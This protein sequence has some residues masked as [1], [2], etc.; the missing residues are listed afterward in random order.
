[1]R[2][3]NTKVDQL[4]GGCLGRLSFFAVATT[5]TV[6]VMIPTATD[7]P[8]VSTSASFEN[9][10]SPTD[11]QDC[12]RVTWRQRGIDPEKAGGKGKVIIATALGGIPPGYY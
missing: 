11:G 6:S 3:S 1:M 9:R 10:S 12:L 7:A 5:S 4:S 8:S 2:S